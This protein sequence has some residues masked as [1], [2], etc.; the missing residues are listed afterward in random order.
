MITRHGGVR[1]WFHQFG[2]LSSGVY[3]RACAHFQ[4]G[5][6][7]CGFDVAGK[8]ILTKNC[9]ACTLNLH[10]RLCADALVLAA[11]A[12]STRARRFGRHKVPPRTDARPARGGH[13]AARAKTVS[14]GR[15]DP[16]LA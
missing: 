7:N 11:R 14:C 5:T 16:M 10:P 8:R 13:G 1:G 3:L 15:N 9:T 12:L 4:P 6:V 2:G